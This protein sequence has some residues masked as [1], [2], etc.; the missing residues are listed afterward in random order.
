MQQAG[1]LAAG[2]SPSPAVCARILAALRQPQLRHVSILRPDGSPLCPPA[3]DANTNPGPARSGGDGWFQRALASGSF[4]VGHFQ[5]GADGVGELPV[6]LPVPGPDGVGGAAGAPRFVLC[7]GL[8]LETL[9][10]VLDDEP[11]PEGAAASIID[12]TG[13]ILARFPDDPA[14]VGRSAPQAEAF[15]PGLVGHGRDTWESEGV[16]GVRRIYFLS[17]LSASQDRGLFL[18]VGMPADVAFAAAD[19]ALARNLGFI[20]FMCAVVLAATWF[21]SNSLVL[22][23]IKALWLA[24]RKLAE[25]NYAHRIGP[26]GRG[27]LGELA[28]AFDHMAGVLQDRTARLSSAEIKYREIFENSVAGIFQATPEGRIC[29]ANRAM[30]RLLG[31]SGPEELIRKVSDIGHDV[32]AKPGQRAEVLERLDRDGTVSSLEFPARHVNGEELWLS[33]DARAIRTDEGRVAYYEA[34]VSDI[35]LRKR[36]EQELKAKQEKLHA[37]MEH[38]PALISI[39]DAEGRYLLSSRTHRELRSNGRPA[40]G[41]RVDELFPPEVAGQILAEDA[42]V[43]RTGQALT[44]QRPLPVGQEMRHFV[45]IK[46][47]LRDAAGRPDRVG[48]ISYDVT[49]LERVREALRQSEEKFRTMIQTSPDLIWLIDP[50]GFL[51]EVNSASRDLI[52]YEPEEL[53]GRHFSRFFH[54]EDLERHDR[55]HVLP[56]LVGIGAKPADAPKLINERRQLPRSTRNLNLRLIPKGPAGAEDGGRSFELSSCGLWQDMT[57]V[58]TIVVIRDITERRRAEAELKSSQEL[59]RQTQAMARIGGFTLNL[60]T[61]QGTWTEEAGRLLGCA[62]DTDGC[63]A[64]MPDFWTRQDFLAADDRELFR[65]ALRRAEEEGESF[66]LELLLEPHQERPAGPQTWVR[67]MG[68]RADQ[69]GARLLSGFIQDI[70]DRKEL[71]QLKNDIDSIIRHDLKAPLNGIINLPVLMK[72]DGNLSEAQVELLQLIEDSGRKMLR[73]VDMSLDLMKIE[74]GQYER[75]PAACDLAPVLREIAVLLDDSARMKRVQVRLLLDGRPLA[76][77]D[78]FMAWCE[79]RLCHPMLMNLVQN[80]LDASPQGEVVDV[81]LTQ[82]QCARIA[83]RNRGEVPQDIRE[84]FFDKYATSGKVGGTGL[85][86]YLARLFAEAQSGAVELDCSEPDRTLITVRLPRP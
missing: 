19:R 8:S 61:R 85:G 62:A 74:R 51:V 70:T 82:G 66:D 72:N 20:G 3:S 6:A 69:D 84:R 11:L 77:E 22:R 40:L 34:M 21:F 37:L 24:T 78:C 44:R 80:A 23:H 43:L 17:P 86:T 10:D 50:D 54:A 25:G 26:A 58:G 68:R 29:D 52:G 36:M 35:T 14:A 64:C 56:R 9:K 2:E 42:E 75:R 7:L 81:E 73:Q 63:C 47:P 59:L 13:T 15:L 30:A 31:Y 45:A 83:I 33:M 53:R 79:E 49:D 38:S 46:F 67:F 55:E 12:R 27:E 1:A 65:S 4:T 71:E 28:L 57:F 16:D 76:P 39:K 60:D 18:R 5:Q 32:Y 48:T 41:R